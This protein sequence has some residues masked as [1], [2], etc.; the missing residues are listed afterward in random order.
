MKTELEPQDIQ[1]IAEKVLE[2]LK[3]YLPVNAKREQDDTIFD[4]PGRDGAAKKGRRSRAQFR[5]HDLRLLDCQGSTGAHWI[6]SPVMG[7]V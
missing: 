3:P 1:A 7:A 5:A 4:V 2:L 6:L